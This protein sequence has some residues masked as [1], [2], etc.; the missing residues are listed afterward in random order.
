MSKFSPI[1]AASYK[2]AVAL[3]RANP[4]QVYT[5]DAGEGW[6]SEGRYDPKLRRNII[7]SINPKGERL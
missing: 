1:S 7:T 5:W 6:R 2:E 4:T 3:M